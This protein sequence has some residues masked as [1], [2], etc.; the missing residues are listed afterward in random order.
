[1]R[2]APLL[3]TLNHA[4]HHPVRT[5]IANAVKAEASRL[6]VLA[7]VDARWGI[8]GSRA[9]TRQLMA[10]VVTSY[11]SGVPDLL[12]AF[13]RAATNYQLDPLILPSL[14]KAG[15]YFLS[16]PGC[17]IR[18]P[19]L[20]ALFAEAYLA[21]RLC[22]EIGDIVEA[23]FGRT[24]APYELTRINVIAHSLLGDA[25]AEE[26]ETYIAEEVAR[27]RARCEQGVQPQV[28]DVSLENCAW[29]DRDV[30]YH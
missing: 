9:Q 15:G 8:A 10:D 4:I 21:H 26:L 17:L 6:Q 11:I 5:F 25:L 30:V 16:P 20:H 1:M 24:L 18:Y 23:R 14:Q 13:T 7:F 12:D 28:S 19:L 3:S 27:F 22:E 29:R 2:S